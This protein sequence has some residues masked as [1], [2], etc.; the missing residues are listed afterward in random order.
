M[1]FVFKEDVM[2]RH[3]DKVLYFLVPLT[4]FVAALAVFAVIPFGSV[5][6]RLRA[7][8]GGADHLVIA[9]GTCDVGMIYVF[10]VGSIAVY[11]VLLGSWASNDKYSFL[12]GHA[13]QRQLISYEIPMG[14][15]LLGVV[16]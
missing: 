3:V 16:L 8:R 7:S 4:I 13:E 1:K 14:L 12:G 11:G 10:A 15:A 9:A 5:L 6:P 2:P